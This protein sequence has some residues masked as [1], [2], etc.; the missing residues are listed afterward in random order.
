ML[1]VGLELKRSRTRAFVATNTP[2]I[3]ICVACF[4]PKS[5]KKSYDMHDMH[6]KHPHL[7]FPFHGEIVGIQCKIAPMLGLEFL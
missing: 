2:D 1:L 6:I 5:V 3:W 7:V 4:L